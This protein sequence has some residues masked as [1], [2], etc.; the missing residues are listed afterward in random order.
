MK[1]FITPHLQANLL[2]F[3]TLTVEEVGETYPL[4]APGY[5]KALTDHVVNRTQG[6]AADGPTR[7]AISSCLVAIAMQ[8]KA[9]NSSLA[10]LSHMMWSHFKNAFS[11][12]PYLI[13][14]GSSVYSFHALLLMAV[15]LQGCAEIRLAAQITTAAVRVA[16]MAG[17]PCRNQDHIL[18]ELNLRAFWTF[19]MLDVEM[20]NKMM[21]LPIIDDHQ[22]PL[23]LPSCDSPEHV[24]GSTGDQICILACQAGH[25]TTRSR[26]H[27]QYL[28]HTHQPRTCPPDIKSLERLESELELWKQNLPS[29]VSPVGISQSMPKQLPPSVIL[30]HLQYYH[31]KCTLFAMRAAAQDRDPEH[32]TSLPGDILSARATIRLLSAIPADQFSC[33]W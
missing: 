9:E 25:A 26:I 8:W 17:I 31:S 28:I 13:T 3:V 33:I 18:A 29:E 2:G 10:Q 20:S 4:F 24:A 5:V 11:M 1:I 19:G 16:Q 7:L 32:M 6:D 14:K 22:L 15:F 30:L 12:F 27:K 21:I 23:R